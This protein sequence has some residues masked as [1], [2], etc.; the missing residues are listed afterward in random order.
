ME[1]TTKEEI[2]T[3][4]YE[5]AVSNPNVKMDIT[6]EDLGKILQIAQELEKQVTPSLLLIRHINALRDKQFNI[7]AIKMYTKE[8]YTLDS[9]GTKVFREDFWEK[10]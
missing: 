7:G 3:P 1:K 6:L 5:G 8:D 4:I 2:K 9:S 10:K